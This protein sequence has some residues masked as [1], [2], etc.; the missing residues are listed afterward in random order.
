MSELSFEPTIEG[1]SD[2]YVRDV[3]SGVAKKYVGADPGANHCVENYWRCSLWRRERSVARGRTVR[4][5]AQR[6]VPCLTSWAV[7]AYAGA[8]EF[9]GNA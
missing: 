7:H 3:P 6:L 5:L 2:R 8:A 1:R 4:D 9:V